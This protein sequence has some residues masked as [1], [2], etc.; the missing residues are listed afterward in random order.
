MHNITNYVVMNSSANALLA[1][2][3]IPVMAHALEE[4][5]SIA[6]AVGLNIG[7]LSENW[8][9]AMFKTGRKAKENGM[10]V[11][12]DPVGGRSDNTPNRNSEKAYR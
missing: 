8:I 2:G 10:P 12:L 6:S 1:L 3:A 9:E 7:T 11:I 4:M 5:A